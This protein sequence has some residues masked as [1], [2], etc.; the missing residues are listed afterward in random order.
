M[1]KNKKA[2]KLLKKFWKILGPGLVTGASD[3]DPSGIATYSQAGAQF[4]LATLWTALITFPLMASIQENCARIGMV[5]SQGLT[6]TLKKNYPKSI[7]Y[8]MVIFSFPA[9]T[10]N[11]GA[12]LAG[13]GAVSNLL[14]P[15]IH[16]IY[17]SIIFTLI[18]L[19]CMIYFPYQKLAAVLKYLC[20]ILLV[21]LIIPFLVKQ[22]FLQII[23]QTLIPTIH[24]NKEYLKMLVA[25]LGTTISPYLFFW[26][27]TMEVEDMKK[28]QLLVNKKLIK[29][30][31]LDVDFGMLFSN[32]VMFFIILTTGTVL[33]NGG[34]HQIDT[35]EQAAKALEPLAGKAAYLLF[36]IGVIGT[37]FLAIPV[38][39]G[40]LSYII[41]ET[42]GWEEGFDKKFH[43]AK[44]F[45]S[46]IGISLI[47]GLLINYIG[48]SPIQ[49]LI[50]SAVLYGV[51][52][53]V[54]IAIILHIANNK[55]V[56]GEFTNTKWSNILGISTFLLMAISSITLLYFQ[57]E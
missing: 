43:E 8:L 15:S 45:Y 53:P 13:M 52:A 37:G 10:L 20:L 27:A 28:T 41:S 24:L 16:A 12:D 1:I 17:F 19:I 23:K 50:Y 55:N 29:E 47:I 5:T 49:A 26:Q 7:L 6:G 31:V 39:C 51:T 32:L 44:A 48:I 36:A 38:L 46:V 42:F 56:M 4:G 22:N 21:Y 14:F 40:S 2:I 57:W 18:L 25:L 34:I 11:I 33:F 35:V 3:D 30:M 54:I 9:I